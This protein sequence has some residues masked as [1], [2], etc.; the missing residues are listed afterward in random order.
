VPVDGDGHAIGESDLQ[1]REMSA[2]RRMG[3]HGVLVIVRYD[4]SFT[5]AQPMAPVSK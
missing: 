2:K 4:A 5:A 1:H 3:Y